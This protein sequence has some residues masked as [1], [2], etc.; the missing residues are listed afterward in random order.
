M[1]FKR[2]TCLLILAAAMLSVGCGQSMSGVGS[3]GSRQGSQ[4]TGELPVIDM[5]KIEAESVSAEQAL[6]EAE[7]TVNNVIKD[8]RVNLDLFGSSSGSMDPNFGA[9]SLTGIAEKLE[10]LL[11][12]VLVKLQEPIQRAKDMINSARAQLATAMAQLDPSNPAHAEAIR[13]IQE[14]MKR[15]DDMEARLTGVY[16]LLAQKIDV[17]LFSI[18]GLIAR[19]SAS[20]NPLMF[21]VVFELQEVRRV[22][23]EFQVKLMNL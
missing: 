2:G 18:D 4:G 23:A 10:Q 7:A 9:Q 15:L 11:N 19:L 3:A 17:V 21:V 1:S 16:K 12:K 14:M 20:G 13:R 8:G 22:L 6:A 5:A